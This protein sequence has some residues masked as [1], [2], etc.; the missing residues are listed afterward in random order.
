M[1]EITHYF[2]NIKV[3]VVKVTGHGL[4]LGDKINIKGK[5]TDLLQKVESMQI[6]SVDVKAAKKGQLVGLKLAKPA[7]VGDKVFIVA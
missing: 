2:A 3:A 5:A 1:G 4:R 6:E 7:R